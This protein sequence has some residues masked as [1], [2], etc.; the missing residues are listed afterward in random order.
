MHKHHTG[1]LTQQMNDLPDFRSDEMPKTTVVEWDPLLGTRYV[2]G[3][4]AMMSMNET[5][6]QKKTNKQT[7]KQT[8]RL[9][10]DSSDVNMGDWERLAKQI[11]AV[12]YDY[13]GFVVLH[14][15]DTM[16]YTACALSFMLENLGKFC[17]FRPCTLRYRGFF[18]GS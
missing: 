11:E 6:K 8:T 18:F 9:L 12:Y 5:H 4:R 2:A 3:Q 7:N 13:D 10:A 17:F 1:Y 14:G 15:T 16:A